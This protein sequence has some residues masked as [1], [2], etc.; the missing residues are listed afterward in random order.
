VVS[1][2]PGERN[3]ER[4]GRMFCI[5]VRDAK[6]IKLKQCYF[7]NKKDQKLPVEF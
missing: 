5:V 7:Q 4:I 1:L 3:G 6:E 2:L